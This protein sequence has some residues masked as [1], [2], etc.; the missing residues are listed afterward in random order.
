MQTGAA[1]RAA[2]DGMVVVSGIEQR[3]ISDLVIRYAAAAVIVWSGLL[4]LS[5]WWNI[6]QQ[7]ANTF[8]LARN[9]AISAFTKDLAYRRWASGHGGVY[10]EPSEKTPPSPWMSHLPDRDVMTN[11]G[12]ML[13]LMNPAYMLREMMADYGDDYGIK[14]RI[15]GIVT[16]NPNNEADSWEA[17][18]IRQFSAGAISEKLELA[19]L[20]G[21]PYLRLIRPFMMEESCQKCHGHLGFPNGSV[22]GA[23]GVSVPMEPFLAVQNQSIRVQ[24]ISHGA[25]WLVGLLGIALIGRR[26]VRRLTEQAVADEE[27]RLAAHVFSNALEAT[28][29]TDPKGRILRVNPMFTELTGYGEDEVLGRNPRVIRSNHHDAEFYAEIWQ[30]IYR[31]GRWQG[32]IW[33]RRKD[34]QVFVAWESIVAVHD[35]AGAIRYFIGI[36]RDITEQVEAQRHILRLAHYD[37][38]TDLPNRVLFQDRLERAVVHALRHDRLAALLFLDLDGFK[39]VNDTMGHRAGDD[40]LKEVANRL[41]TCV[42]MTDTIARLGG[43]EFTVILDEIS[44]AGDAA[45]VADKILASLQAPITIDGREVFIGTSIGISLFPENGTTGDVLLKHADTAMY[46]AKAAGKG[47][48]NFYSA[49]MTKRQEHRLDLEIALRQAVEEGQFLVYYQPKKSTSANRVCG[50]EA[51]VRWQHPRLGLIPPMDFIPLA[52]EMH[53]VDRIDLFVMRQACRKGRIWREE[54]HDITI[55]V[56]LSG[57]NFSADDLPGQVAK[58]LEETGFPAEYLE[59]EITESFV[60]D[61][62]VDKREVLQRLRALGVR[63]S[64]DDFGTGYSSLS[65]LKRLPVNTLKI[66][67]SFVRDI[68]RDSRDMMLVS[69]IIGIAHS[70][71]LKVV[72]EGIEDTDQL[73]ILVSLECDEIQGY[74]IAKPMPA[75][76]AGVFLDGASADNVTTPI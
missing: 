71:G 38:L 65:Y 72:A 14:G 64:I 47:C 56:N 52:E 28:I 11:D 40:L 34:G 61:L 53:L 43:D 26:S 23:V 10:V 70:L 32:E 30:S 2:D 22:R 75:D 13:T 51:L 16:L 48:F 3:R 21:K 29:I 12:R 57:V 50:F 58:V 33:N 66:D 46:Q 76:M 1:D 37:V 27:N 59:L 54:G 41:R 31:D 19:D 18:A 5:L 55:A 35:D 7:K 9:T 62:A 20:G 17:E 44:S 4:G 42:R 25:F 73:G 15:V 68:A 8:D 6:A 39:K 74:L 63:L 36:F 69:S 24:A 49:E 45:V 60:I 67:R